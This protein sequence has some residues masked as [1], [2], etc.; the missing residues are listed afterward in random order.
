MQKNES[1]CR[2]KMP[3]LVF[4]VFDTMPSRYAMPK[5]VIAISDMKRISAIFLSHLF[6]MG[7]INSAFAQTVVEPIGTRV[8]NWNPTLVNQYL[9]KWD[10]HIIPGVTDPFDHRYP[11]SEVQ[12]TAP[13]YFVR[14]FTQPK[15]GPLGSYLVRA[16]FIRGLTPAQIRR[17]LALPDVPVGIV[18]V[19]VPGS[20][21]YGL[22]T[23]IA[24]A[25]NTPGHEWGDGGTPQTKIIGQETNPNPPAD[26]ARFADYSRLPTDSYMNEALIGNHALSY[27]QVVNHGNAG[28]I[29]RYLDHFIPAPY[30]DMEMVYTA[31][32]FANVDA[33][34]TSQFANTLERLSPDMLA[35]SAIVAFRSDLLFATAIVTQPLMSWREYTRYSCD[36]AMKYVPLPPCRQQWL[37]VVGEQGQQRNGDH[38]VGFSY[39]SGGLT[40]GADCFITPNL[41]LGGAAAYLHSGMG[42]DAHRGGGDINQIKLGVYANYLTPNVLINASLTSGV[43][44]A[45]YHRHM[46]FEGIG[47]AVLTDLPV[48]ALMVDRNAMSH[49]MSD[50]MGL[51]L[52]GAKHLPFGPWYV[53]PI[54]NLSY[55]YF[56]QNAFVEHGADSLNWHIAPLVTQTL[57]TQLLLAWGY[58]RLF[59]EKTITDANMWIGWAHD[60][61]MTR[62]K[63]SGHLAAL[64]G[65]MTVYG[66][67]QAP[68]A[69]LLSI[70][71]TTNLTK[72]SRKLWLELRYQADL[73]HA[74]QIQTGFL[75]LSYHDE[76]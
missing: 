57:R 9:A 26:P 70:G 65:Q 42:V 54:V 43:N 14:V 56:H 38:R 13:M 40:G 3:M 31:L 28:H 44:W 33:M 5:T 17:A 50:N 45:N 52:T 49:T 15:S 37:N 47:Y 18:Y 74:L 53:R 66:D 72:L 4:A 19:K 51:H 7:Q 60:T 8:Q 63:I 68:N 35:T 61:L 76:A 71:M 41:M 23:G 21:K 55:F 69:L 22:W 75:T 24:G 32:D 29:A 36:Q 10:S 59:K 58:T 11:V 73:S 20:A 48:D 6:M 34:G 27:S 46:H 67:N 62:Q 12:P 64:G 25:I 39:Q 2:L 30:S 1:V 16:Q